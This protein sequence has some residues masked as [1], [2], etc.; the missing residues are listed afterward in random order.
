VVVHAG[1]ATGTNVLAAK[2][3]SESYLGDHHR[4]VVGLGDAELVVRTLAPV[5]HGSEL[6]VELPPTSVRV[7]AEGAPRRPSTPRWRRA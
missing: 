4:Y 1:P 6:T 3:R 2:V 7:F 5:A